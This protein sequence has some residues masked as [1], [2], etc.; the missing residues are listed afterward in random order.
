VQIKDSL[1][2]SP[3]SLRLGQTSSRIF[4][5]ASPV[6]GAVS[7]AMQGMERGRD[8]RACG[9]LLNLLRHEQNG[10]MIPDELDIFE[11][12]LYFMP[13]L[14]RRSPRSAKRA[15][16]NGAALPS[17]FNTQCS[18]VHGQFPRFRVHIC[19]RTWRAGWLDS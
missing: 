6:P 7:W 1:A 14:I 11:F 13:F 10:P 17:P 4:L 16:P 18:R 8:G 5:H 15:R 12:L 19:L 9:E 2:L 3:S